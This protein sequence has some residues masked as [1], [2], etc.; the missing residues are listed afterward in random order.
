MFSPIPI[1]SALVVKKGSKSF[2]LISGAIPQPR[3]EMETV[4][5]PPPLS[6]VTR[7]SR[8]SG[9]VAAMAS[10]AFRRRFRMTCW[11]SRGSAWISGSPSAVRVT[12]RTRRF[13]ASPSANPTASSTTA[14]R[15]TGP[16]VGSRFRTKSWTRR[17]IRPARWACWAAFLSA[18]FSSSPGSSP[19]STRF[20]LPVV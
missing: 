1:P 5:L 4:T 6:A 12:I 9:G 3:S 14:F 10:M 15:R 13:R 18:S 19:A 7:S 16:R 17:M 20:R 2:S 8:A 11:S